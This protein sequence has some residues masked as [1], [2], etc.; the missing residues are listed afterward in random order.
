LLSLPLP[1]RPSFWS[2]SACASRSGKVFWTNSKPERQGR[3]P[4]NKLEIK[5][6][7]WFAVPGVHL[8]ISALCKYL[9]VMTKLE[10]LEREIESL[11]PQDVHALGKWLDDL[12]EQLW[13]KQIERDAHAGKLDKLIAEARADIAAGR[14]KP[15]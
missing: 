13:D 5:R 15:L 6:R 7:E 2:W 1:L 9:F 14:V 4:R 10:R 8:V 12:R 11:P 3:E